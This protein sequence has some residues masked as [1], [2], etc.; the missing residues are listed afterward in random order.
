[1]LGEGWKQRVLLWPALSA[2]A[3]NGARGNSGV[4]L[5]QILRGM[6]DRLMVKVRADSKTVRTVSV[7]LRYND[8]SET[9]P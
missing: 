7:K 2:G 4:I 5:S 3:L 8:F 6:A 9:A 1:M